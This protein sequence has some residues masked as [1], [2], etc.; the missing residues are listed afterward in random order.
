MQSKRIENS[1]RERKEEEREIVK[2]ER[3]GEEHTKCLPTARETTHHVPYGHARLETGST[4][5]CLLFCFSLSLCPS[6]CFLLF[7]G[8][9][10]SLFRLGSAGFPYRF[11]LSS[12][13]SANLPMRSCGACSLEISSQ[14][15][16]CILPYICSENYMIYYMI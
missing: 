6:V 10:F 4:G 11:V 12:C 16:L 13:G 9:A 1:L 5:C 15:M 8:Y 3:E 2:R 7:L 14:E